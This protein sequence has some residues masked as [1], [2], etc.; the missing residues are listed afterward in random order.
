MIAASPSEGHKKVPR[1]LL[2]D[3]RDSFVFVLADQFA[4]LGVEVDVVRATMALAEWLQCL[5]RIEPILVV[6]S[7]GPGHP[8]DA[9]L[10]RQW[11][12][13]RPQLP[14]FVVCLGHQLIALAAGC[15]IERAPFPVHGEACTVQWCEQPFAVPL[16]SYMPAARYH[17]LLVAAPLPSSRLRTL[18]TTREGDRD[19]V[20]AIEHTELPQLGVQFHPESVLTPHGQQL[21]RGVVQWAQQKQVPLQ[22]EQVT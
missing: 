12:A 7:P 22:A 11:L 13:T 1:V 20:M 8:Q 6:L 19:L 17:S 9:C 16:P 5:D 2:L 10:A 21:L 15:S 3:H 4:R 14:V 18:A